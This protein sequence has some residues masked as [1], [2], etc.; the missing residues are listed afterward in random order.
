MKKIKLM[1]LVVITAFFAS[2]EM[3]QPIAATSNPVGSKTGTSKAFGILLF[4]PFIGA[5]NA[6]I[7]KAAKSAGITKISTVD[8]TINWFILWRTWTC[9]VTGE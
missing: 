6:G 2:C 3:T 4:P 1:C 9:K 8:Y 7:E 5:G